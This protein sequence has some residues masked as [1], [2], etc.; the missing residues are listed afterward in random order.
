[1][2]KKGKLN[3]KNR[4]KKKIL[5]IIK[6]DLFY[7]YLYIMVY[8]TATFQINNIHKKFIIIITK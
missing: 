3:N 2:R 1:M 8:L 6:S 7:I 5:R 4:N